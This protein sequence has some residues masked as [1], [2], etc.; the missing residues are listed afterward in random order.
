MIDLMFYSKKSSTYFN[1]YNP[2]FCSQLFRIVLDEFEDKSERKM[3]FSV[4]FLV[5]PILLNRELRE[6]VEPN[7]NF[8]TWAF[9]NH[10]KLISFDKTTKNLIDITKSMLIFLLQTKSININKNAEIEL[11]E[12]MSKTFL[13]SDLELREYYKKARYVGRLL[14]FA[15][16]VLTTFSVL[17]VKP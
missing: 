10:F 13:T 5:L 14:S 17:G 3:P 4:A 9:E 8:Y 16:D 15:D 2:A 6:S 11:I 1:L 12:K 7:T